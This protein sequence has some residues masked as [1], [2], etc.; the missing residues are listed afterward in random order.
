MKIRQKI[1]FWM[2]AASIVPLVASMALISTSSSKLASE[3]LRETNKNQLVALRDARKT[4]IEDY[5]QTIRNQILTMSQ[6]KMVADAMSAFSSS[7]HEINHNQ[8]TSALRENLNDYY[9]NQFGAQYTNQNLGNSISTTTL[10]N[11]VSDTGLY[12][13][14]QYIGEN[15][16]PLGSKHELNKASGNNTYNQTHE[17]YHHQFVDFL[18]KF[19]FYDI[20]LVDYATGDVV[21]S[22]FKELDFATSL[23]NGPYSNSGLAN[24]FN[25][26]ANSRNPDA[27]ALTD[28]APY[29][30]SY[31]A[32]ASFIASPIADNTG[33]ISGVLVF[34]MP[35]E[36]IN[37]LMTSGGE[38]EKNGLGL[39]GETYLVGQ[40]MKAKSISRFLLEDP[41]GYKDILI[42]SGTNPSV[43]EE[44]ISRG[45][46]IGLQEINSPGVSAA[47]SGSTGFDIFPD[48]RGISVLSAFTPVNIQGLKWVILSEIDEDE[49]FSG[50][51][52]LENTIYTQAAIVL[53]SIAI[54]VV[55]LGMLISRT[56]TNPIIELSG[57]LVRVDNE[58]NLLHRSKVKTKD[59]LGNMAVALNSMLENF[60]GLIRDVNKSTESVS[61]ASNEMSV[62]SN[63]NMTAIEQQKA[64]T[65]QVAAAMN[66]MAITIK[67]VARHTE[68]AAN[69]ATASI[70][71]ADEG[72]AVVEKSSTAIDKL[73]QKLESCTDNA[74]KL[75]SEGEN[76]SS[77][78]DVIKDISEQTN[79]LALN[80]A[81]EA[82]RAGE[83]GRGFAVVADEVRGL[84][85][86]TQD[87]IEQIENTVGKLREGTVN[88]VEAM[89]ESRN[90]A[91]ATVDYAVQTREAFET[92]SASI[93]QI[94][95]YSN[96]ISSAVQ[97]QS[98]VAEQI[99][100]NINSINDIALQT[101]NSSEQSLKSAE[102]LASSS[103]ELKEKVQK[104]KV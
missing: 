45:S 77:I 75:A 84:A 72:K 99:N 54:L 51:R 29:V 5:F 24:A 52:T 103:V 20:F 88:M 8:S 31:S 95:D 82:A 68:E 94:G 61:N 14:W 11:Q 74:N 41:N 83:M 80:A 32:Q 34:Q 4:Q 97:E 64:E 25:Q 10:L 96:T 38:W 104:F 63:Q 91:K 89:D 27:I 18:E 6:N 19:G 48:Y 47:V 55:I 58:N 43:A 93:A 73:S 39:S 70:A 66:Q 59:E 49:A 23:K 50:A 2:V 76:I 71:H 28:F 1:T 56:V 3:A 79:L 22:V 46:N 33:S 7:F 85:Q 53:L 57:L 81:I 44:I 26:V 13:Q 9:S 86:R 65:E 102:N 17:L 36:K 60:T 35:I 98:V 90:N 12:W 92:I 67:E 62:S 100:A 21:Y 101:A 69:L 40:D 16:H 15:K 78:A 87:S 30:P 42:E 37:H